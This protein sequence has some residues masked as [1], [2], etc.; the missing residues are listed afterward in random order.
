[1]LS[2]PDSLGILPILSPVPYPGELLIPRHIHKTGHSR[3]QTEIG[4]GVITSEEPSRVGRPLCFTT[5]T[6]GRRGLTRPIVSF[7]SS[8]M[9]L[10]KSRVLWQD[11][12]YP[13]CQANPFPTG[14]SHQADLCGWQG[15]GFFPRH[16]CGMPR[17]CCS[18]YL[19]VLSDP[20]GQ[21]ASIQL[22]FPAPEPPELLPVAEA[23]CRTCIWTQSLGLGKTEIA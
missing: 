20:Q 7:L 10:F 2:T 9:T 1:M 8:L 14:P 18:D 21:V 13:A 16:L 22:N 3:G 23:H 5:Q 12:F 15:Q 11:N 19:Q 4:L 17:W 6:S